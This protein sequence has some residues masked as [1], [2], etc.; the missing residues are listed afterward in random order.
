MIPHTIAQATFQPPPLGDQVLGTPLANRAKTPEELNEGRT[1][2]S[3]SGWFTQLYWRFFYQRLSVRTANGSTTLTKQD[4]TIIANISA[5][6]LWTLPDAIQ[7][8]GQV[9]T[10]KNDKW[11]KDIVVLNSPTNQTVDRQTAN[12]VILHPGDSLTIQS[13]GAN[14]IIIGKAI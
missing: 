14:W 3:W 11:S 12:Q 13:D 2:Q 8:R 1:S 4:A 7:I 6:A 9:Y 5:Q 10:L